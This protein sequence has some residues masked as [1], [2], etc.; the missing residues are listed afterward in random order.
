MVHTLRGKRATDFRARERLM[1][2][3]LGAEEGAWPR[4]T[5][6]RFPASSRAECSACI[7]HSPAPAHL[8]NEEIRLAKGKYLALRLEPRHVSA[9]SPTKREGLR[10]SLSTAALHHPQLCRAAP[11]QRGQG[12][13]PGHPAGNLLPP[14]PGLSVRGLIGHII[15]FIFKKIILCVYFWPCWIFVAAWAFP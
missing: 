2:E 3:R 15:L 9:W 7:S 6:S 4:V 13:A 1:R 14:R 8:A 10:A 11:A 5:P 12:L